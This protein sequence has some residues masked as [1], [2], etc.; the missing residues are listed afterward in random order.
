M[1][2]TTVRA[3]APPRLTGVGMQ[4]SNSTH[5]LPVRLDPMVGRREE[6]SLIRRLLQ[7]SSRL[8]TVTGTA[9][10]GKSRVAIA[11]AE[12]LRRSVSGVWYVD[13]RGRGQ[14]VALAVAQ[15][16]KV[17]PGDDALGAV[18]AAIGDEDALLL[19]DDADEAVAE[20]SA[21]IDA[22][23]LACPGVRAI[24]TSREP[25]SST[26]QALVA[27]GPFAHR[28][29]TASS[30]AVRLF[31]DRAASG[32]ALFSVDESTL[33]EVVAIC[34]ATYGVPLAIE[35][36]AAQLQFMD[37]RTLASRISHQLNTLE[38]AAAESRSLRAA[39][40][41]S[42]DRCTQ[43]ERRV[44]SDLSV[45][46]P[47]WDLDLG[48][49]MAALSAPA[50]RDAS[51]ALKQLIRR[52]VIHRRRVEGDVRYELLP[53]L[54]EFGVEQATHPQDAQGHFVSCMLLRLHDAEDN[55]FS[56]RQRE[57]LQR[58]RGDIANIRRAVSTAAAL[59]DTDR[60]VEVAVTA[61]RQAWMLHGSGDEVATWLG[62]AFASGR[63]SPFWAA[64]GHALRAAVFGQTGKPG[65]AR[66]ELAIARAALEEV[67]N[68][69]DDEAA[70][71]CAVSVR[72]AAEVV[73]T[74][75]RRALELLR[76][77]MDE[78]G[79][80][81]YR[82]GRT[83]T[84]QRL[85]ARL[86]ALG[87]RAEGSRVDDDITERA[88]VVGDRFER[89]FALTTRASACATAGE[90]ET[91]EAD[92]REALVVKRGL[93]NGLGVAQ[94][95]ELLADV[96]RERADPAR[97]ATLLGAAAAR[98]RDAGSIRA[99]YPPYFYDRAATERALRHRLGS[100]SFDRAFAYGAALSE[101]ES[102]DF[103]LH[104]MVE[105]RTRTGI[106]ASAR[107]PELT[108]REA[109]VA[110]LVADGASNKEIARQLFVSIRTVETHVQNTLVKLGLRSR[111]ELALW[112]REQTP[113]G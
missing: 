49:A 65:L 111:T 62:I 14:D 28:D 101:E 22:L 102:I 29:L 63:P 52:S 70:Q 32:D 66:S 79:E 5:G 8:V 83:N 35:L 33:P 48:E 105:A 37:V 93:G 86:H 47:G 43:T 53:A 36:A 107:T 110:A 92:A 42:W 12:S 106:P 80:D 46:A 40:E 99:N 94:A 20:T 61:W 78:L 72:S 95:L 113:R 89:S 96:A 76:I 7:T 67:A 30:D 21:V 73:D 82:F 91:T 41:D 25:P 39:V 24:V 90:Y 44:W 4:T 59:G 57:I 54:R 100:E 71:D 60:A 51:A 68:G 75:D 27:I 69:D 81:A 98:W 84:P 15:E 103:A 16:L 64:Q 31:A 2:Q 6:V 18:I 74:D 38:P 88:L 17:D 13:V 56:G 97:G 10:V 85:A 50:L 23:L 1:D 108:P 58:L 77:L 45:L 11:A 26:A 19:I 104:G 9:G 34:E 3:G 55:W 109:Q 112:H 87:E